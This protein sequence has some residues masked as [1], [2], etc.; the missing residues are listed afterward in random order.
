MIAKS[1]ES[2]NISGFLAVRRTFRPVAARGG[3]IL[4]VFT[5]PA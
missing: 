3:P 5:N 2:G 1:P 4:Y